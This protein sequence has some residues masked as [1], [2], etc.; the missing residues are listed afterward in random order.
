MTAKT[1]RILL[2][3]SLTLNV[4]VLGAVAGGA[5]IWM[6]SDR[7][8]SAEATSKGG[9]RLAIAGATLPSEQRRAFRRALRETRRASRDLIEQSRESRREAKRLLT[10]DPVDQ[11]AVNAALARARAADIALRARLENRVV[12][13]AATLPPEQRAA[14][15]AALERRGGRARDAAR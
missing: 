13:F 5:F 14:L 9:G 12:A 11:P 15:A 10:Q 8:M 2:I 7:E 6:R 1:A 4:F 3:V